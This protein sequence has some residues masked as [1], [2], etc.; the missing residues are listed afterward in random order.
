MDQNFTSQ[1]SHPFVLRIPGC[2]NVKYHGP[3]LHK[4]S[5]P[6][7]RPSNPR[8]PKC[9]NIVGRTSQVKHPVPL[10]FEPP[11]AEMPKCPSTYSFRVFAFHEIRMQG[12]SLL[13]GIPSCQNAKCPSAYSFGFSHFVKSGCKGYLCSLESPV[14]EMPKCPCQNV[15][16]VAQKCFGVRSTFTII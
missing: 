7:L 8:L 1:A 16:N 11:V 9:Q 3:G 5:V 13:L 4:S 15:P 12:I 10:S 2:R 14:A 6:S